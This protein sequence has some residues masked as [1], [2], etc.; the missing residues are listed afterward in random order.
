MAGSTRGTARPAESTPPRALTSAEI[1]GGLVGAAIVAVCCA[2]V[3]ADAADAGSVT[4]E[5][6]CEDGLGYRA[7]GIA[8]IV[9]L[10]LAFRAASDGVA[11]IL[12]G[13]ER[14]R[15]P[16]IGGRRARPCPPVDPMA[17]RAGECRD[18]TP[19][20]ATRRRRARVKFV[21]VGLAV[22]AV[23]VWIPFIALVALAT[24]SGLLSWVVLL[25]R[26]WREAEGSE[27]VPSRVMTG[28]RV[29][30][31]MGCVILGSFVT[32]YGLVLAF[33]SAGD[34]VCPDEHFDRAEA[35]VIG[36]GCLFA[37]ALIFRAAR[38]LAMLSADEVMRTDERPPVLY[39]RS[40]GDDRVKIRSRRSGRRFWLEGLGGPSHE[41]FEEVLAWHLWTYGPL[42]TIAQ[43][44]RRRPQ[45]VDEMIG[46]LGVEITGESRR[47]GAARQT[48]PAETWQRHV[49]YWLASA[50]LI[51]VTLGR[52][53]GLGWEIECLTRLGLWSKA[54]LIFPPVGAEELERRWRT[55][56]EIASRAGL[57]VTLPADPGGAL[58][59]VAGVT[60]G[61]I[62]YSGQRHDEWHYEDAVEGAAAAL[63]VSPT[64]GPP[65]SRTPFA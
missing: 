40:F 32:A 41:R 23:A 65:F 16:A 45:V 58:V 51:A 3:F 14:R 7:A 42:V 34:L 6:R 26:E 60:D 47:L 48:L 29:F 62:V 37:G 24:V 52:T 57:H 17:R 21:S 15:R 39:L 25:W 11:W 10:G 53:E 27:A 18:V 22:A 38:R 59:A 55:F 31:V 5:D 8:G 19:G 46:A 54:V 9:A 20:V 44:R 1:C 13:P 43:P 35:A 63:G 36:F 28:R 50:R 64:P 30:R 61:M 12:S 33:S 4:P 49:E 56:R 2:A